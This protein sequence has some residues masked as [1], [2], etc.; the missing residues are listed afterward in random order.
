M[1]NIK[2][3]T[4]QLIDRDKREERVQQRGEKIKWKERKKR[5]HKTQNIIEPRKKIGKK[6]ARDIEKME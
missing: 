3:D 4:P 1:G 2:I 5:E 6:N